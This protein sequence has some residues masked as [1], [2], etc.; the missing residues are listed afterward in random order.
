[1]QG[2]SASTRSTTRTFPTSAPVRSSIH[3]IDAQMHESTCLSSSRTDGHHSI[4]KCTTTR[5]HK[6]QSTTN[7]NQS[8]PYQS[9]ATARSRRWCGSPTGAPRSG[10]STPTARAVR[11]C[12]LYMYYDW[13]IAATDVFCA[14]TVFYLINT[15]N[16]EKLL[17][18]ASE[19][20]NRVRWLDRGERNG[21]AGCIG[22]LSADMLFD[23]IIHTRF[24]WRRNW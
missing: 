19:P 12:V 11:A 2:S 10:T 13:V 23:F 3:L 24:R 4:H 22:G 8:T 18:G 20:C 14:H 9:T 16:I 6:K 5:T 17:E 15:V 7:H 21:S 1:V